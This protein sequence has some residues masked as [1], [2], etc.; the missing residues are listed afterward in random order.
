[1][2][3]PRIP[4]TRGAVAALASA[5]LLLVTACGYAPTPLPEPAQSPSP[6]AASPAAPPV[7]DNATQSYD[8]LSPMPEPGQMPSGTTMAEIQE[9]GRLIV[10]TSAD[11]FLLASRNPQSGEVEGFDI[12][13]AKAVARAIFGDEERIQ[14]RIITAAE[15]IPLLE[16][17]E[18]DIVVRAFSMTCARWDQVAF[19]EE[20]YHSGQKILVRQGSDITGL[21]SLAGHKVCAPNGTSSLANL[22]AMAPEA[23]PVGA[24]N[25]TGCLVLFQRGAVDAITGDDTVLAGLAAQ[26][27]YAVVL[28]EEP[29]TEE[30]YGIGVAKENTDLAAFINGVLGQ[31]RASGEW[32]ASYQRWLAPYLGEGAG[33]PTPVHGRG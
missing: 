14:L 3:R 27:P 4:S 25:H 10:G 19:S 23:E 31:L 1:M 18:V 17:G 28:E 2:S 32:T 33:Q 24:L 7:C 12:D 8:P 26:D 13:M 9:R 6:T 11:T 29:F 15:R 30:P 16:A 21:S 5:T 20:Y 22:V